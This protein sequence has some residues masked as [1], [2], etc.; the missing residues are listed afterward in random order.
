[1]PFTAIDDTPKGF[2]AIEDESSSQ[3][4]WKNNLS[5][6]A[7]P[8]LEMGGAVGGSILAGGP[9]TPLGIAGGALGYAGGKS[10]ADLLSRSLGVQQPIQNLPQAIQETGQNV[11]QGGEM[12][13]AGLGLGA[14]AG[15]VGEYAGPTMR[16]ALGFTK[17]LLMTKEGKEAANQAAQMA[18]ENNVMPWSGDPSKAFSNVEALKDKTGKALGSLR[19]SVG[20]KPV[21]EVFNQ[22]TS[23]RNK[24]TQGGAVGGEWDALHGAIDDAQATILGLQRTGNE[25]GEVNVNKIEAAKKVITDGINYLKKN[26]TQGTAKKIGGAIED[27]VEKILEAH[28]VDMSKYADLKRIYGGASNALTALNGE[29]AAQTGNQAINPMS[30]MAG[31]GAVASGNPALAA[32]AIGGTE[33][34]KRRGMGIASKSLNVLAK[35]NPLLFKALS[36]G[37]TSKLDQR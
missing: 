29:V 32:E 3:P 4:S 8:V 17:A 16:R 11:L 7:R 2:S 9:E 27:G 21:D 24:L 12:E 15:K 10:A 35:T 36:L 22:L 13:A 28:G 30:V 14:A 6:V 1:M 18:L 20:P 37:L 19:A 23:L 5:T 31:V 34:L 33:F 26:A 25:L